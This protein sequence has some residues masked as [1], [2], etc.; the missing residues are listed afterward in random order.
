[1]TGKIDASTTT[2]RNLNSE[3]DGT[4]QIPHH[5]INDLPPTTSQPKTRIMNT[6]PNRIPARNSLDCHP[7]VSY[8]SP[9]RLKKQEHCLRIFFQNIKG[10]SHNHS[11]EDYDYYLDH[12]RALQVDI[13]GLA[14]TNTAWQHQFLRHDFTTK[15]RRSG[16]GLSKT[17]FGSPSKL[18]D[19][20]PP[21]E[22]YQAGGSLTLC[23]GRWTTAILGSDIVDPTGLGRWSGITLR[24]KHDNVL[25]IISAYR[26]CD[27]S[28][29]TASLGSTYHREAEY[30][31]DIT[32]GTLSQCRNPRQRF[33]TELG[34]VILK[35]RDSGHY[36]LLMLDANGTIEDDSNLRQMIA[37]SGLYN[38]HHMDPAPST[39]IGA[40]NRRI[41]LMLG[42]KKVL[43]ST[44]RAGTLSYTEG[45]QSDHRALYID[46]DPRT[47]LSYHPSD[48]SIQSHPGRALKTGNPEIV[49]A[50]HTKNSGLLRASQDGGPHPT[51]VH[52][53]RK[54]IGRP[55]TKTPRKVGLG[56]RSR[57]DKR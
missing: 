16:A 41:D 2:C 54:A 32:A 7:A 43:E 10:L 5:A 6:R 28:R 57:H 20:I 13:A 18:V 45:P 14:E 29:Q 37:K 15:A 44:I 22:T 50:Y 3:Q 39:Y 27:G 55:T 36:V 26:T 33:L 48:N 52:A 42:C 12:F 17:S 19:P 23:L 38:L 47:L 56:S 4:Q 46:M 30:Y 35:Y 49:A 53:P 34:D 8:G 1:M 31:R 40:K 25:H 21:T 24:G 51:T 11:R 9:I